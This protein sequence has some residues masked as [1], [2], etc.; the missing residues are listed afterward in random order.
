LRHEDW[1]A[2]WPQS[3]ERIPNHR[4]DVEINLNYPDYPEHRIKSVEGHGEEWLYLSSVVPGSVG[5]W[6]RISG[7]GD[8]WFAEITLTYDQ[9]TWLGVAVC[10]T[11]GHRISSETVWFC[12]TD[13]SVEWRDRWSTPMEEVESGF[14]D[15]TGSPGAQREHEATLDLFYSLVTSGLS[16]SAVMIEDA[17]VQFPQTSDMVL[18]RSEISD[19]YTASPIG[20][21]LVHQRWVLGGSAFVELRTADSAGTMLHL[22]HFD[23]DMISRISDYWAPTLDAP[24]WRARWVERT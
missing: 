7:G 23:G 4:S 3:G 8:T 2:E 16:P 10:E 18:G 1:R 20:D 6:V 9:S 14:F 12:P 22:V 15:S 11:V 17:T 13:I 21:A 19:L 24:D 5:R